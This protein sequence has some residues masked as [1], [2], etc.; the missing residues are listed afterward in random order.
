[1]RKRMEIK[2]TV[3]MP[4]YNSVRFIRECVESV[5][6]QS[7][8]EMEILIVDAG[9]ADGT[10][11]IL[12]ELRQAD[13]RITILSSGK[14]SCGAQNNLGVS[15]ARG[16][17]IGFV[18]SDDIVDSYMFEKLYLAAELHKVDYIK[19]EY[20]YFHTLPGERRV[21]ENIK[22]MPPELYNRV[23]NPSEH[24]EIV[25][26]D[27]FMWRGI[28]RKEF[29][30]HNQILQNETPGAAFQ[31]IGF[32]FQT[33]GQAKRVYYTDAVFYKYRKDNDGSSIYNSNSHRFLDEEFTFVADFLKQKP[34]VYEC[35]KEEY[36]RRLADMLRVRNIN[37]IYAGKW[38]KGVGI[39]LDAIRDKFIAGREEGTLVRE[40]F[41]EQLWMETCLLMDDRAAYEAYICYKLRNQRK[42]WE[43]L[44]EYYRS[45]RQIILFGFGYMGR[46]LYSLLVK[47]NVKN[48]VA[49]CDNDINKWYT[50]YQGTEIKPV[51]EAAEEYPAADYIITGKRN[52]DMER[53]LTG[54]GI[55][56]ERVRRYTLGTSSHA[57]FN[58][59]DIEDEN[60]METL[61]L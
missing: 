18:E 49:F 25:H 33:I 6:N 20:S 57:L 59:R 14:K 5:M 55:A 29:L 54:M 15:R 46:F 47:H 48:I 28:Y 44:I 19:G 39:Y 43:S 9:S 7:L 32:L 34:G 41:D 61:Q 58:Y 38:E 2:V 53:Q 23:F 17:Y 3:V 11:D 45:R 13:E 50:F 1:M 10:L 22:S 31:D 21:Y 42:A 12:E 8:R 35:F 4:V 37:L 56:A 51:G 36:Y 27:Y 26:S 16:K 52:R 24:P 60:G 40:A 30:D